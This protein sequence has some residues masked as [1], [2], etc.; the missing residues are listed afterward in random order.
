[1]Y[2][3]WNIWATRIGWRW[4]F[5]IQMPLFFVSLGLTQYNL[6]YVTPVSFLYFVFFYVA[7]YPK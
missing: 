3:L 5:L 2:N 1:M 7:L 6:N 4:A